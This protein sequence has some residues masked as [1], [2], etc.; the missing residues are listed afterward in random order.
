MRKKMPD[1]TT[2]F[3]VDAVSTQELLRLH[4]R[5]FARLDPRAR[6]RL[7]QVMRQEREARRWRGMDGLAA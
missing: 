2:K 4:E 6:A 1:W 7:G 5:H 3:P